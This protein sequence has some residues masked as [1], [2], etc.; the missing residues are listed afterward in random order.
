MSVAGSLERRTDIERGNGE[1]VPCFKRR[2]WPRA[3]RAT[4]PRPGNDCR[5]SPSVSSA[6][7]PSLLVH[8]P[9]RAPDTRPPVDLYCYYLFLQREGAEDMLDFWLDVQQHENLCRAYFGDLLKGQHVSLGTDES[10]RVVQEDWPLYAHYAKTRGS[11][12]N[13][14]TGIQQDY[15]FTL[16]PD[17]PG[18]AGFDGRGSRT[19]RNSDEE[20]AE[21]MLAQDGSAGHESLSG[22]GEKEWRD[23]QR[24]GYEEP[25]DGLEGEGGVDGYAPPPSGDGGEFEAYPQ[26]NTLRA[27]YPHDLGSPSLAP[28]SPPLGSVSR[29][30]LSPF[31]RVPVPTAQPYIHRSTALSRTDLISSAERIY[32]RYLM[33][34]SQKEIYL[35]S[36]LRIP[37]FPIV[38]ST[39]PAPSSAA[40]LPQA[41]AQAAVPDMFHAQKEWVYE[42]LRGG[43]WPRFLRDKAFGNLVGISRV[44]RGGVGL[45][46]LWVGLATGFAFIF[47][48]TKPRETRLWVRVSPPL[49]ISWATGLKQRRLSSPSRSRFS[50]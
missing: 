11:I 9:D 20:S 49:P 38:S 22:G 5:R 39:L 17:S 33:P 25:L 46:A 30:P 50:T 43:S 32:S 37:S 27:L 48:D 29:R 1:I 24:R 4:A 42:N 2:R 16:D 28:P 47:L 10:A 40:Y 26:S 6:V 7:R 36:S 44:V 18:T 31:S 41:T 45:M 35:P 19:A 14:F 8:D 21:A 13:K 23:G 15:N 34:N 3:T 12:Y